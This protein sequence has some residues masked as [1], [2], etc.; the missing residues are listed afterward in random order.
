MG[1]ASFFATFSQTRLAPWLLMDPESC[2]LLSDVEDVFLSP[3]KNCGAIFYYFA[4]RMTIRPI[5][6]KWGGKRPLGC[7]SSIIVVNSSIKTG[8]LSI[9]VKMEKY[10]SKLL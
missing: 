4:P 2:M 6:G 3:N 1:G 8:L 10:R 5:G 9:P 7:K